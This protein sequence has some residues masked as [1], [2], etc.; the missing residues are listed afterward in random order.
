MNCET[1]KQ[2]VRLVDVLLSRTIFLDRI[3]AR[4]SNQN[5]CFETAT[6][7]LRIVFWVFSF[8]VPIIKSSF[9]YESLRS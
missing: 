1:G 8:G 2:G 5:E 9:K 6:E 3:F 7:A 4:S